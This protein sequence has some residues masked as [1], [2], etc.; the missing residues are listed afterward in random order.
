MKVLIVATTRMG[1]GACVGA[2]ALEDGRSLRLLDAHVDAHAGGGMHYAVGEVWEIDA[3]PAPHIAPPHTEDILV[4]SSRRLGAMHNPARFIEQHMP[5]VMG[6]VNRLFDGRL[7][8]AGS[9]ALYVAASSGLPGFSTTFWR[10]DR[11]LRRI[12]TSYRIRYAYPTENGDVTLA[13]VGFQEPPPELPAGALLR[14]SLA[15]PWRPTDRPEEELRCYAQLSG[16]FEAAA[17]AA[18]ASEPLPTTAPRVDLDHARR[19]LK[20]VFGYDDFRPLQAEIIASLLAG[21]DTLAIMPTG[22]GK[23]IC[24]QLPAL[25][26]NGMT[27]VVS[28]LIALM[29]DQVEQLRQLG[30]AA[31][32]LNSTLDYPIYAAT[33][34]R[35][36]SGAIKL[37]YTS[38]E[39]LLRPETL[40]M[41][42]GCK[43]ACLAID[44]AHCISEWGHDFRP[45]YRQLLS[46]RRHFPQAVCLAVTATATPRVQQ[47]IK[48]MLHFSDSQTFVA[49]FDR[50]NLYLSVRP[51]GDGVRQLLHFLAAHKDESGIIYCNTRRQ[52][53]EVTAHLTQAGILAVAYHAG[54]ENTV[55]AVN[56]RRFLTEDGCVAV[57]TIAFGM[58]IN[59]PDVR[60]VVHYSLPGSIE[61]YYQQIG[62]AGRDGLPAH[63]LLLYHPQDV[64]THYL[65]IEEG[66]PTERPGRVAR[67]QAMDRFA[68]TRGCR[69][70]PLL[71]YFGE[72]AHAET[73]GACDNCLAGSAQTPTV[74]VTL[75]A[76]KFLSCVRRTGEQFGI[77]YV[78]DV[79]RGSHRRE[80]TARHHD[81]LSTHGIG[82]EHAAPVWRQLAQEFVLQGLV[83]QDLTHGG[84][85]LTDAGWAVL[86]KEQAVRVPAA[87]LTGVSA[88]H[89]TGTGARETGRGYDDQLFSRLRILRRALADELHIPAYIIFGD[90]TLIEM[91][92]RIPQSL[93]ELRTIYGVGEAKL[94]QFGEQF[95][96]CVRTYCQEE[97]IDP[98]R[99]ASGVL[100]MS[101][102]R[103]FEEVG[104]LFAAG[105]SVAELQATFGV[106]RETIIQHL[107]R[108][109]QAGHQLDH[110]R[111]L[112]ASALTPE[113]RQEVLR[114]LAAADTYM[115]GP[116]FEE[117]DGLVP[118]EELRLLRLYLNCRRTQDEQAVFESSVRYRA[119]PAVA[120]ESAR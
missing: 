111:L 103:R 89:Q 34:A 4:Q 1:G 100:P 65:H 110:R 32:F 86:R 58:G 75:E 82:K 114:R 56:Q 38:P 102:K 61:H 70:A 60:F 8:R 94:R 46:A 117:F 90:R 84:L 20:D 96:A 95:L 72:Q 42:A 69:R 115:L 57:A 68:R 59:K 93:E 116:I 50:P 37:L 67:L 74:D 9:G 23:S 98:A 36:R 35:I 113:V 48:Q 105:R 14:V 6:G 112:A 83:D 24:Y 5:P 80:I 3:V 88:A 53:E 78:V 2:I 16:W 101:L 99:R 91:A 106:K 51:R 22:S 119:T 10:P 71:A 118:Y 107:E 54:L 29:Q 12:E 109:H 73:C 43:P 25:I 7:Q 87:I 45:E 63:C 92:A 49:S 108:Y 26:F 62:R 79:L 13:F 76:Q 19:L 28:P 97:G 33:T 47:D 40:I 104:E 66:A 21:Q 11:P 30:I 27:I 44:E 15:R 81:R 31:A 52:V 39:T 17:A 120:G 55:R 18:P 85:R 64:S 77:N 41:L